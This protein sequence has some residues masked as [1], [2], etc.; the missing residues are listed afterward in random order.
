MQ[1]SCY[2]DGIS[3]QLKFYHHDS[4]EKTIAALQGE[5]QQ[6]NAVFCQRVSGGS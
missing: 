3:L 4:G 5:L 2:I 6:L 1:R